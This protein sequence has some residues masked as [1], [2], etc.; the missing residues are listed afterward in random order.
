MLRARILRKDRSGR[1]RD[2]Q[3]RSLL[4]LPSQPL[5]LSVFTLRARRVPTVQAPDSESSERADQGTPRA[6]QDGCENADLRE[7]Q[8]ADILEEQVARRRALLGDDDVS[9]NLLFPL[10]V[11]AGG[12]YPDTIICH[13]FLPTFLILYLYYSTKIFFCQCAAKFLFI[14]SQ[15]S[16]YCGN[17]I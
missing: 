16:L 1:P 10:R 8:A 9:S 11:V 13:V 12:A 4:Q 6:K 3:R 5:Q 14:I 2:R 7:P 15:K 17:A